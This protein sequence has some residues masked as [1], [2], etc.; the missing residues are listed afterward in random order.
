MNKKLHRYVVPINYFG[1]NH[2][3]VEAVSKVGAE[4]KARARFDNGENGDCPVAGDFERID[5]IGSIK[6]LDNKMEKVHP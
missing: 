6:R 3:I 2:Y 5:Y 4:A 1:T